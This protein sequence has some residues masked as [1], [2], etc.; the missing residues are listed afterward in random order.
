MVARIGLGVFESAF[1]PG[2]PLYFG[3]CPEYWYADVSNY[4][5]KA[6]FY[7]RQEIGKRIAYW[8][9]FA[10]VAGAFSGLIAFGIQ[11]VRAA[12]AN[13]R[14]LFIIEGVPTIFLGFLAMFVLPNRPEETHILHGEERELALERMNRGCKADVGRNLNTS[15]FHSIACIDRRS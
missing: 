10:A 2:F 13:W 5:T 12:V 4:N 8:F 11:H 1:S 14:L 9:G 15:E 6:L 7:T 3:A